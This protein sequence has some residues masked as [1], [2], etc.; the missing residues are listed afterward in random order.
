MKK[1]SKSKQCTG[2]PIRMVKTSCWLSS[3]TSG[4]WWAATVAIYCRTP[5]ISVNRMF[6]NHPDGL[7]CRKS[8][9]WVQCSLHIEIMPLYLP[10]GS[11]FSLH[12]PRSADPI[13]RCMLQ[14][15]H[16]K[17]YHPLTKWIMGDL[18]DGL[19]W[20]PNSQNSFTTFFFEKILH[21]KSL[22]GSSQVVRICGG[23]IAFSCLQKVNRRQ[24]SHPNSHNLGRAF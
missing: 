16:S 8:L 22:K 3:D 11:P 9:R 2:W 17:L 15:L 6:L 18:S 19:F 24:L 5:Q 1:N 23:K 13:L 21:R 20:N 14:C 4:S 12:I 7:P 10:Q